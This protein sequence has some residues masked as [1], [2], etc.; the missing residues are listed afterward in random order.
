MKYSGSGEFSISSI[1]DEFG[2]REGPDAEKKV[3]QS[4]KFSVKVIGKL[5]P[6]AECSNSCYFGV[7]FFFPM[8]VFGSGKIP[9]PFFGD[10]I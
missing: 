5:S 7:I 2:K 10:E 4:G 6:S 9:T 1:W 3:H 8:E